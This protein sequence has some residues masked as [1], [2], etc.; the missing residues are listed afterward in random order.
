VAADDL[1]ETAV[2]GHGQASS[3]HL[4]PTSDAV[5]RDGL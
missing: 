5:L 2:L 3:L 4:R 1:L